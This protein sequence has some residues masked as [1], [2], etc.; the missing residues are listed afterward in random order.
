MVVSYPGDVSYILGW[1]PL[2]HPSPA[3]ISPDGYLG[4]GRG[5]SLY[6]R[7]LIDKKPY[8]YYRPNCRGGSYGVNRY[9]NHD[10]IHSITP[11]IVALCLI[12]LP[13]TC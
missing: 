9:V 1:S 11:T 3:D 7:L 2:V 13:Y 4:Q 6:V 8:K 10:Y 5:S 12:H